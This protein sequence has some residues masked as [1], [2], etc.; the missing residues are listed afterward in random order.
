VEWREGS[1]G[2]LRKQFLAIR[3]HAGIGC[4]RHSE[5]HGRRWTGP[6][7]WLLGERPLPGEEGDPK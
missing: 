2:T 4:A 3:V 6:E 1:R 5:S 7:G